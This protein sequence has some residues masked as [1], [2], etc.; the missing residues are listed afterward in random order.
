LI[1]SFSAIRATKYQPSGEADTGGNM[2][3][4]LYKN[5]LLSGFYDINILIIPGGRL[6][7]VIIGIAAVF[8]HEFF[9]Q[10]CADAFFRMLT[11]FD[12]GLQIIVR[13]EPAIVTGDAYVY[14]KKFDHA[15]AYRTYFLCNGRRFKK[16]RAGTSLQYSA[17]CLSP[18]FIYMIC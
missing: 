9:I 2:H 13:H 12:A 3:T 1:I 17:H 18:F 5:R 7:I 14:R 10:L 8:G 6:F 11:P 15:A 16:T 4:M